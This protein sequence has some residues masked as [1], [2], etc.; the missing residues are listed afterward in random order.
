MKDETTTGMD[1]C[2]NY[3]SKAKVLNNSSIGPD[4]S[5]ASESTPSS[6]FRMLLLS[7]STGSS[8]TRSFL[9][10]AHSAHSLNLPSAPWHQVVLQSLVGQDPRVVQDY[11]LALWDLALQ[12]RPELGQEA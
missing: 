5:R 10:S 9:D 4:P 3:V 11:L 12:D 6:P 8:L 1:V 7:H 2:A